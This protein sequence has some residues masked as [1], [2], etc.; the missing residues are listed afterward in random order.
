MECYVNG[1]HNPSPEIQEM[2]QKYDTSQA[3]HAK[4]TELCERHMNQISACKRKG[5]CSHRRNG[6]E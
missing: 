6:Q 3:T 2:G 5:R 4:S 1:E